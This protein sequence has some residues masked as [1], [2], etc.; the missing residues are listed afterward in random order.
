[1]PSRSSLKG[2]S[3]HSHLSPRGDR[4]AK[5]RAEAMKTLERWLL[6]CMLTFSLAMAVAVPGNNHRHDPSPPHIPADPER[7]MVIREVTPDI[8]TCSVPFARFGQLKIGGRATIGT[9]S[10]IL[11][12]VLT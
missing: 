8:L 4:R 12:A 5:R 1:M 7:V 6:C 11:A 3:Q 10:R 2:Y 9:R